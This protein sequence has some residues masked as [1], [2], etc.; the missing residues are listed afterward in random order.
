MPCGHAKFLAYHSTI[1]TTMVFLAQGHVFQAA[2]CLEFEKYVSATWR[3]ANIM[4]DAPPNLFC[5][6]CV[7]V[8]WTLDP[9]PKPPLT[10]KPGDVFDF[11]LLRSLFA[12][13]SSMW[14][15]RRDRQAK[16]HHFHPIL[17]DVTKDVVPP[18]LLALPGEALHGH[19][20]GGAA[21]PVRPG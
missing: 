12:L 21:V 10:R 19:K 18:L 5:S 13:N 9:I 8:A 3:M 1:F 20:G 14:I 16:R 4:N 2:M 11:F 7:S 17:I 6:W 15:K